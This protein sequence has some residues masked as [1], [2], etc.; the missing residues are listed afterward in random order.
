MAFGPA[1]GNVN[2]WGLSDEN[3]F[4]DWINEMIAGHEDVWV[5]AE[6][7]IEI[8]LDCHDPFELECV[9]GHRLSI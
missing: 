5:I 9:V 4:F 3:I 1:K 8:A 2:I 7:R 6:H